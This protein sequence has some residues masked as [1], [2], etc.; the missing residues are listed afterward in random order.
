MGVQEGS[1]R[2]QTKALYLLYLYLQAFQGGEN[3]QKIASMMKRMSHSSWFVS[4]WISGVLFLLLFLVSINYWNQSGQN[5]VLHQRNQEHQQANDRLTGRLMD[6]SNL[7]TEA[8]KQVK[9]M[10]QSKEELE[11]CIKE[12]ETNKD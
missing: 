3:L 6:T 5:S 9:V 8:E 10:T 12:Q 1:S 4:P 11:K 7:L 2:K